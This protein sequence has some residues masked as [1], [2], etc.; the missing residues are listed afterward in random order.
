MIGTK[1]VAKAP[2]QIG[3][4]N[5]MEL[6]SVFQDKLINMATQAKIRENGSASEIMK[7]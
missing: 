6:L 1:T 2:S 4:S 7:S 3:N 5:E